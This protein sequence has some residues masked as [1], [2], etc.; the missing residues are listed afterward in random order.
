MINAIFY[1]SDPPSDL[2]GD[3][4]LM[5]KYISFLKILLQSLNDTNICFHFENISNKVLIFH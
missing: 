1:V 5:I 2:G 4:M 3:G